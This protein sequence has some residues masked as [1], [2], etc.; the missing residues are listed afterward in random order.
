MH[1]DSVDKVVRHY[2]AAVSK[3]PFTYKGE[4]FEP[5]HAILVSPSVFDHDSC[6]PW[7]GGCCM[8]P[9]S[10]DYIP[11]E[12]PHEKTGASER[13]IDFNGGVKIISNMQEERKGMLRC[14]FLQK[15]GYCGIHH[16]N[17]INEGLAI[18]NPLSCDMP[19]LE[20]QMPTD[21]SSGREPRILHKKFGR[22]WNLLKVDDTRGA[23]CIKK[24]PLT[25][26]EVVANGNSTIRRLRR[27]QEWTDYFGLTDTFLPEVISWVEQYRNLQLA[28][29]SPLRIKSDHSSLFPRGSQ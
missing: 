17:P 24:A 18:Q 10:L 25:R 19:L 6:P 28:P 23:L 26:D 29:K 7:C 15:D 1:L 5:Y 27:L 22:G 8:R 11:S 16:L 9:W 13:T 2:F 12:L 21:R 20:F 4:H 3:Q 14:G